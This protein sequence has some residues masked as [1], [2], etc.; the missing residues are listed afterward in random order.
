MS[1]RMYDPIKDGVDK[2]SVSVQYLEAS[3]PSE[4]SAFVHS[5]WQLKTEAPLTQDFLLHAIP[6]AC[7]NLLFNQIDTNIAGVT[8]L[9]TTYEVLN[10]GREFHYVGVQLLP[11]VWNGVWQGKTERIFDEYVGSAYQGALPLITVSQAMEAVDF[12]AKQALMADFVLWLISEGLVVQNLTTQKILAKLDQINSVDDMARVAN[13]ST[14]QLQRTLKSTTGFAPHDLLKVLRMQLAFKKH[15]LDFYTDQ[16]HFIHSF[17]K[18]VGY[19]PAKFADKFN[20][21]LADRFGAK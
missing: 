14:R 19:T 8:A 10:L 21:V 18:I 11:G 3:P 7:V 1:A 15:Y 6:D 4:L 12:Q 5:F 17:R 9:R 13:L 16:A 2:T 20:A